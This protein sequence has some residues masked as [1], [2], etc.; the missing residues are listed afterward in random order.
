ML[1]EF[2]NDTF[3][4]KQEIHKLITF[5]YDIMAKEGVTKSELNR[6]LECLNEAI[7]N[8]LMMGKGVK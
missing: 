6:L 8:Y 1:S 7:T 2:F 5:I 4:I 3:K